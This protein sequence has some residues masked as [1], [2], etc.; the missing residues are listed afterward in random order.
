M[1]WAQ[2]IAEA[3][4][5]PYTRLATN[6]ARAEDVLRA[7]VPRL[8][9]PYDLAC[10]WAGANNAMLRWDSDT[11]E[12]ALTSVVAAVREHTEVV[13]MPTIPLALGRPNVRDAV[14]E[15][16]AIIDRVAVGAG[17]VVVDLTDLRGWQLVAPDRV[18]L[19]AVGQLEV[20]DRGAAAL[21]SVGISVPRP[22][23]N[24]RRRTGVAA[25]VLHAVTR[26]SYQWLQFA[27]RR[28]AH[29]RRVVLKRLA[30]G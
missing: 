13:V 28:A 3:L 22:S 27:G 20:A 24:A 15:A 12:R 5:I 19:T 6:G 30:Q 8:R 7:Q 29:Y 21:N 18:H 16:N 26:R 10:V 2:W 17:A 25:V 9:G 14:G 4:D 23:E 1:S 11:F